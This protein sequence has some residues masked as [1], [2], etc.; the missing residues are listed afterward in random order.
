MKLTIT[1]L[2]VL[3]LNFI[4]CKQKVKVE[5]KSKDAVSSYTKMDQVPHL[6]NNWVA[7]M[8]LNNGT[9]WEA[10]LETTT[11][12][13]DMAKLIGETKTISVEDYRILGNR[14]NDLKNSLV[15]ECTMTGASHDN[16]HVFLHPLIQKIELLKK[17][18]SEETGAKIEENIIGHLK[19]DYIYFD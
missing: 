8:T 12:V 7:E 13:A 16:L 11:G 18:G 14:L 3:S 17:T 19:A 2:I 6:N 4:N 1:F 9:K 15:M 10:N 5:A